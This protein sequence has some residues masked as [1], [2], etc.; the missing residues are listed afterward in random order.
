M[1]ESFCDILDECK[2]TLKKEGDAFLSL[3]PHVDYS[4]MTEE[5]KFK[6]RSGRLSKVFLKHNFYGAYAGPAVDWD[7]NASYNKVLTKKINGKYIEVMLTLFNLG[8]IYSPNYNGTFDCV[9]IDVTTGTPRYV[10]SSQNGGICDFGLYAG[11]D[12]SFELVRDLA[13]AVG[14]TRFVDVDEH[15]W[16]SKLNESDKKQLES[17]RAKIAEA[18]SGTND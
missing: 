8:C 6:V 2:E 3:D 4:N 10:Q 12:I 16:E 9:C 7:S 5:E 14:E 1:I 18:C 13:V 17:M 15:N 11:E